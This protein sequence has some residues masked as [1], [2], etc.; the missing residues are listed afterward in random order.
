MLPI[1]SELLAIDSQLSILDL[2]EIMVENVNRCALI[3]DTEEQAISDIILP[4]DL[5]SVLI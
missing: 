2:I 5:N 3:L 1:S 4:L